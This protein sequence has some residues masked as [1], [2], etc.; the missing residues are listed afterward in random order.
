MRKLLF[1]CGLVLL[2]LQNVSAQNEDTWIPKQLG[3]GVGIGTTGIVIDA[4][5]TMNRWLG[6]RMGV[7]IFPKITVDTD[8]DL[9]LEGQDANFAELTQRAKEINKA[10]GQTLIDLSNFPNGLPHNMDVEGQWKNTT[11]HFLIDVYPFKNSSFHATTGFYIGGKELVSVSNKQ[12]GFLKPI[13]QWNEAVMHPTAATQSIITNHNLSMIG[14]ELG[15][16]FIVPDENGNAK[17]TIEVSAFRPYLGIGFGRAVPRSGRIGCQFDLGVQFWGS[18]KVYAPTYDKA[19][20]TYVRQELNEENAGG[21]GGDVIKT[22][23][24]ISVY[25]TLNFR[26]VGRIL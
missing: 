13:T 6:V 18:P 23:S 10:A 14:A 8:L 12:A 7:D 26:L 2:G 1:V 20:K 5:T 25:P 11:F 4:S 21:D 22:L 9:G 24:K 3:I 16:Y 17:A 15:D 19:T